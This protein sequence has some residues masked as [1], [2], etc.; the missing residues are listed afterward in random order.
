MLAFMLFILS[1]QC[2]VS[3]LGNFLLKLNQVIE[4]NVD[5]CSSLLCPFSV[6]FLVFNAKKKCN[7]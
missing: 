2:S 7:K 1:M 3:S 4:F 5:I 6:L